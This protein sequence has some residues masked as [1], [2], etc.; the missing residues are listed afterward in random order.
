VLS[1]VKRM[2]CSGNGDYILQKISLFGKKP[3]FDC[4]RGVQ[5]IKKEEKERK[6]RK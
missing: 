4:Y 2:R 1:E 6:I 3:F 5:R